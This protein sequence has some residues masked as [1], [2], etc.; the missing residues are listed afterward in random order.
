MESQKLILPPSF[1]CYSSAI[2]NTMIRVHLTTAHQHGTLHFF[3]GHNHAA[4]TVPECYIAETHFKSFTYMLAIYIKEK[5]GQKI[6]LS[7]CIYF[8]FLLIC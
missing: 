1:Y 7:L 8:A 4:M 5:E 2:L 3:P 6:P